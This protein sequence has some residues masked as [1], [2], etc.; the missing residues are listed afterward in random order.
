MQHLTHLV[1][2][3]RPLN[4]V[5]LIWYQ[6]AQSPRFRDV[7]RADAL[8]GFE[9]R[10]GET[11]R[12]CGAEAGHR[13][14]SWV[15]EVSWRLI[16]LIWCPLPARRLSGFCSAIPPSYGHCCTHVES[17]PDLWHD[18]LTIN[19][20]ILSFLCLLA[21]APSMSRRVTEG[22]SRGTWQCDACNQ[23]FTRESNYNTHLDKCSHARSR[24][25]VLW[26]RSLSDIKKVVGSVGSKK[27]SQRELDSHSTSG[28]PSGAKRGVRCPR[29]CPRFICS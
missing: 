23:F 18:K 14:R 13:P 3:G 10:A 2:L 8:R 21:A 17:C 9:V 25:S 22:S 7:S 24:S 19:T 6:H 15:L 16:C 11:V 28:S 5:Q 20:Y 12:G 27:R 26:Q 29:H 1:S 4:S